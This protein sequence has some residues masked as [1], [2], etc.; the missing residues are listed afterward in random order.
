MT[1]TEGDARLMASVRAE[2]S[3]LDSG[4]ARIADYGRQRGDVIALWAGEGDLPTPAFICEA[5]AEALRAGHTFYTYQCG[6]P[7]LRTALAKHSGE[8]HGR[9]FRADEF[10]VTCGGMQAFNVAIRLTT[11][12]GDHVVVPS[13][14]WPNFAAAIQIAGARVRNVPMT[15]ATQGWHLDVEQLSAACRDDV[16]AV[17]INSPA[18]PTGWTASAAELKAIVEM[19]RARG[20]WIIADEIYERFYYAG[21]RAPS[22]HDVREP[23]DRIIFINS[24]SKT[25]AMTGLRLGWLQAPAVLSKTIENLIQYS[26][27]GVAPA[28]QW[29]GVAALRE[30]EA[31][32]RSQVKRATEGR[33]LVCEALGSCDRAVFGRP[34]GAFYLFFKIDGVRDSAASAVQIIDEAGVGLAPGAAFGPGGEGYF[35]ICFA[36][37]PSRLSAAME[38]LVA[39]LSR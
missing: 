22:L 6:I 3:G 19:A 37:S 24:F 32:V 33:R 21:K 17:V 9:S 7:E 39:W 16:S 25:W 23:D 14:A 12:P 11:Q 36:A 28:I 5:V 29:A 30:G 31:F 26:T 13:P 35:R 27:M 1:L 38:R 8:L 4:L 2:A 34:P 18:N 15:W 10:L 20:I